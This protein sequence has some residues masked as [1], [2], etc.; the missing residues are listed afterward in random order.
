M[1]LSTA[2]PP[3]KKNR[4]HT[5]HFTQFSSKRWR[6]RSEPIVPRCP[7]ARPR[8]P[9]IW[10]IRA[11]GFWG[12]V[13]L[14]KTGG[15]LALV[16]C[17]A[18]SS[19]VPI[20]L[21]VLFYPVADCEFGRP[22]YAEHGTGLPLTRDDMR[23][24]FEQYAHPSQWNDPRISALKGTLSSAPCTWL[25]LARHDVLL[26]EGLLLG[27]ELQKAGVPVQLQVYED[28]T[29][30]FARWFNHVDSVNGAL[31]DACHV[32][33]AAVERAGPA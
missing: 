14:C 7:Q 4:I 32:M 28:L 27:K 25:G 16:S 20:A 18:L 31:R 33:R 23:W 5:W 8:T 3:T 24:F 10:S 17:L 26:S 13:R 21:Q 12:R 6:P 22:S 11:P 2:P 19:D 29:H 1:G 30:G 9:E 15:N